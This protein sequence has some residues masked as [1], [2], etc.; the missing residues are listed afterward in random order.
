MENYS[1]LNK[2]SENGLHRSQTATQP[3]TK[4]QIFAWTLFDFG[5]TGFS[6]MIVTFGFALYFRSVVASGSDFFW[7]LAVSLS[8][9]LCALIAPPLGAVADVRAGKK[10]F[11]L[12]FTLLCILSTFGLYF[13]GKGDLLLGTLLFICAN[14]GFEGGIVFYDSLLPSIT[15]SRSLGRVSGYGYAMGYLGALAILALCLPLLSGGL[16]DDNLHLFRL[17]FPIAGLFFFIFSLPLFFL[18]KEPEVI[19]RTKDNALKIGITR[20]LSTIKSIRSYPQISRFLL[21][22]FF[23]ND[24]TLTIISFAAIFAEQTLK[25]SIQELIIFFLTV[26][27]SS[28]LGSIIFGF[29]AD[30]IG[31][32]R[33]VVITLIIWLGVIAGAYFTTTKSFFY[34]VGL[35]AGVAMGS[36]QSSSRSL[37]AKLI[38]QYRNA[39]F[40]GLYDGFFGKASAIVGPIMFGLLSDLLGQ[41]F[42]VASLSLF[43]ILG[44]YLI[45]KINSQSIEIN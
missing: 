17:S 42:A 45:S 15:S 26:Q 3:Y 2:D 16:G 29:V 37:M 18:V 25:F 38:P 32:K 24:A 44:L 35:L 12:L 11:L 40:F 14:I 19:D 39:E 13:V 5:N 33:T 7:G 6:V 23:Y 1:S 34:A 43:F 31:P 30:K 9:L 4:L 10:Q 28:I 20:S 8:M 22:F 36:S 41:R 21:A 27:T